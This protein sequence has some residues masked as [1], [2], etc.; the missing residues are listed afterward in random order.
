MGGQRPKHLEVVDVTSVPSA[1]RPL[2]QGQVTIDQALDIEKLLHTQA[3]AS[4]AGAGRVVEG[5]Q[6]GFELADGMATD[7]AGEACGEDDLFAWLVI[8]RRYQGNA[9]GQLQRGFE[10]FR[11]TLLQVGAHLESVDHHING[12]LFLLVQLRRFVQLVE[13]A[14]DARTYKTLGTQLF[15]DR[16]VFA[17]ALANDRRQQHQLG[18]FGLGQHQ[19]DH[20]ADGLSFQGDIVVR[21]A[22]DTHACVEQAQVV[23]DLGNGTH[24]GARVVGRGFLLDGN[25]RRQAF[26]GVD[27]G[28]FHH[29]Q[30]LP[31]VGRQR[32]HIATLT[33]GIQRVERQGRF[34]GA[35][36]AGDDDQF[37]PGQGQ[38]DVLQVVG[39]SPTNQDLVQDGL[40]RRA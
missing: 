17:L 15:E 12:V 24:G 8:H 11:Q 1:Y 5:K 14:V 34:A 35:G 22:G 26:N 20:L 38:V 16:Q 29:R 18:A 13:L 25:S 39:S 9:I 10:R 28:L 30:E 33:F 21:A 36:Q 40:A 3:V 19:V 7:R 27:I 31:G 37:V 32:F 6:F 2:G 4:R 23:V